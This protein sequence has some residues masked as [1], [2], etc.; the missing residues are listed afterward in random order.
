[1]ALKTARTSIRTDPADNEYLMSLKD[2]RGQPVFRNL[3][4]AYRFCS[5][6][7]RLFGRAEAKDTP[8]AGG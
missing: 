1:M 7:V 4:E 6:Y 5:K 3:S 8:A 2:S